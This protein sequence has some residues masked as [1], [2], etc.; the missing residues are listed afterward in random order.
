[1]NTNKCP[2]CGHESA[3]DD[4]LGCLPSGED[5]PKTCICLVSD[6]DIAR[7]WPEW[8]QRARHEIA[9]S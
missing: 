4:V 3:H 9:A 2:G 8:K 6:A 5:A 1:V 7:F